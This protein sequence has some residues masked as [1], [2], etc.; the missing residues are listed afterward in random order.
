MTVKLCHASRV[1]YRIEFIRVINKKRKSESS[2]C[3]HLW[4]KIVMS[5]QSK[6]EGEL[7][8]LISVSSRL[9]HVKTRNDLIKCPLANQFPTRESSV[10]RGIGKRE[11]NTQQTRNDLERP[12]MHE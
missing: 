6:R 12:E 11:L 1:L 8:T 3:Y 4:A 2:F 7:T 10:T 9:H 5:L